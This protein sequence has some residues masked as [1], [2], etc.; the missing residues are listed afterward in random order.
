M[1]ALL[2]RSRELKQTLT[3]FVLDAEGELAESLEAYAAA[4]SSRR[5]SHDRVQQDLIVDMF[6]TEGKVGD[7]TPIDLFLESQPNLSQSDRQLVSQWQRS[8][9]GLFAVT[10]VLPDGF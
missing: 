7:R 6:L 2:E 4:V 9:I 10:Q 1:D 5:D 8:F 3:D